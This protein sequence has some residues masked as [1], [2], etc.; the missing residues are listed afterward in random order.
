M[1]ILINTNYRDSAGAKVCVYDLSKLFEGE[2]FKVTHNDWEYEGTYDLILFMSKDSEVLKAK[3]LHPNSIVGIMDPKLKG[4]KIK[5]I[6]K[7]DFLLVSSIEQRE[8]FLKHNKNIVIY[9]MFRNIKKF[10]KKH[11]PKEKITIG[12]HGNKLH[13][14]NFNPHINDAL[15]E[16]AG[17]YNVEL[18]VMYNIKTLGKWEKILPQKIKINHIQW[19]EKNYYEELSKCDIGIIPNLLSINKKRG[20]FFSKKFKDAKMYS[21]M[22]EDYLTRYKYSTNPGRIYIFNQLGIPVVSDFTPSSCQFIQDG[23]SGF[24]VNGIDGWYAGLEKLILDHQ[25]RQKMAEKLNEFIEDNYSI[26]KNFQNLLKYI[27]SLKK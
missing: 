27:N 20:L 17:K 8:V 23:K 10:E 16:L 15:D 5:E 24:V 25:L 2:G 18:N 4:Y 11:K 3:K 21:F 19:S 22:K 14:N 9:Y 1:K 7:A 6:K 12:Y 26:E 13:L